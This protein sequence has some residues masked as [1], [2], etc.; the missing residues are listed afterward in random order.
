MNYF[1]EN[2]FDVTTKIS[3][4]KFKTHVVCNILKNQVLCK[5]TLSASPFYSGGLLGDRMKS[6]TC[7]GSIYVALILFSQRFING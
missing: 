7:S 3:R 6:E 2:L 4:V 5:C 1:F